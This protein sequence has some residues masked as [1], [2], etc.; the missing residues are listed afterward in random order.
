[1][2]VHD[3]QRQHTVLAALLIHLVVRALGTSY[4]EIS[5]Q[6]YNRIPLR[7]VPRSEDADL[8]Y[9]TIYRTRTVSRYDRIV[10][11]AGPAITFPSACKYYNM[12]QDRLLLLCCR[13][14]PRVWKTS[15]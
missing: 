13:R 11:T 7:S 4:L 14:N 2:H 6:L 9:N 12:I 3:N 1:M 5:L 8:T 15:K 10:V